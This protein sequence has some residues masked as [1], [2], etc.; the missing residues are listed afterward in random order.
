MEPRMTDGQG[1]RAPA[2]RSH[3]AYEDL[4]QE[5]RSV[6]FEGWDFSW[7]SGRVEEESPTWD[8][9]ALARD[10]LRGASRVLDID[11]GGGE[12]LAGLVPLP[13]AIATEPYPPNVSVATARLAPLGVDVR[14]GIAA[15]LPVAAGE[16]DLV[17]NRHGSF[18]PDET[19]RVLRP[20]GVL[21]T[22]Q[23][24]SHNDVAFND[25][26]GV[27]PPID[28]ESHTLQSAV[29]AL[30]A[31]GFAV[32]RAQE[33]FPVT[34]Y[35]DIGAVVYQL[36]AVPWQAPGFDVDTFDQQLR[37][38]ATRIRR[39]GSFPVQGHRFLIRARRRRP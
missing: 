9:S 32:D 27:P 16:V 35:L 30:E 22:Q 1:D 25:A 4:V 2:D 20:G 33:E 38:I 8:Y 14:H 28:P 15:A 29:A 36:R 7:L 5:A 13:V 12:V 26:L 31:V 17:L 34:R 24:G 23:V 10:A 37:D 19:A 39:H 3:K 21:L 11:T 6:A 18:E